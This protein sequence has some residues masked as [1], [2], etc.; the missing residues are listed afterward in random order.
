MNPEVME[1]VDMALVERYSRRPNW[2]R[3][4]QLVRFASA[5]GNDW[6]TYVLATWYLRGFARGRISVDRPLAVKLLRSAARSS[7]HAMV[8][9]AH[10]YEDAN[11]VRRDLKRARALLE[12]AARFGSV[13]ALLHLAW[14]YGEGVGV[15]PDTRK[16]AQL[17]KRAARFGLVLDEHGDVMASD[18]GIARR[19]GKK[20]TDT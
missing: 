5:G 4:V 9:L 16:A 11:G 17:V 7:P 3:F 14:I 2:R 12:K 10:C 15:Q 1:P 20:T 6:A 18:I 13:Y 19:N 8:E